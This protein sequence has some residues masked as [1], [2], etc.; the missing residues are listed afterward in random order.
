MLRPSKLWPGTAFETA[1]N[2]VGVTTGVVTPSCF[3]LFLC[4][5]DSLLFAGDSSP[6][7]LS[8]SM[9]FVSGKAEL[10]E[11]WSPDAPATLTS[12][13]AAAVTSDRTSTALQRRFEGI[14][15]PSVDPGPTPR[16]A[17]LALRPTISASLFRRRAEQA[18]GRPAPAPRPISG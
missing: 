12:A 10:A 6:R 18:R 5:C 17:P 16:R 7:L 1:S 9:M 11:D 2:G 3:F 4:C 13:A 15:S 8:G 14:L